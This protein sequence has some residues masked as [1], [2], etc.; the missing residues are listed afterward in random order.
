MNRSG[1]H[2]SS[3]QGHVE[4]FG[5]AVEG[6]YEDPSAIDPG[7]VQDVFVSGISTRGRPVHAVDAL[8]GGVDN[9]YVH[10]LR[11]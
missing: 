3:R 6:R 1:A 4:I 2:K 8:F 10:V 7:S 9:D 11:T 5:V